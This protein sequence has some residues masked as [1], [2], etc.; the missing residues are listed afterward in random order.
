M[1]EHIKNLMGGKI[2]ERFFYRPEW[3]K[4]E[5]V[6]HGMGFIQKKNHDYLLKENMITCDGE[7]D[8]IVCEYPKLVV[9]KSNGEENVV[10]M[11]GNLQTMNFEKEKLAREGKTARIEYFPKK[12]S[13]LLE[14]QKGAKAEDREALQSL[15]EQ[16]G[17]ELLPNF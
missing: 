4:M 1:P 6:N 10:D 9:T 7:M 2:W 8:A 11:K 16:V 5:F 15:A 17:G 14:R 13:E 3:Q 12:Y